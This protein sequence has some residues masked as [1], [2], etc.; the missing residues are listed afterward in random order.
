MEI[1]ININVKG[2]EKLSDAII[3]LCS[4]GV[5]VTGVVSETSEVV[6]LYEP[7][8]EDLPFC[9][10]PQPE[11]NPVEA[12]EEEISAPAVVS[13]PAEVDPPAP[14]VPTTQAAQFTLEQ[15][16]S[17]AAPIVD[18]GKRE[19]LVDLLKQFSVGSLSELPPV[20]YG[21]FV[22]AIRAMGAQI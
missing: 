13:L 16:A 2:I 20:H 9:E 4:K 22:D 19:E 21:A 15:I 6:D 18:A 3:A 5:F 11:A 10:D 12:P 7:P 17:A 14:V 1:N 8:S